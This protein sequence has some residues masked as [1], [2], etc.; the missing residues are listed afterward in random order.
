MINHLI[1]L[2]I[3]GT[4]RWIC[5]SF[6]LLFT[7]KKYLNLEKISFVPNFENMTT[8]WGRGD[9]EY[10]CVCV[11]EECVCEEYKEYNWG[12]KIT[13]IKIKIFYFEKNQFG[14]KHNQLHGKGS[15]RQKSERRKSKKV[16][17]KSKNLKRIRRL[18]IT[19]SKR[20]SKVDFWRSDLFWRHR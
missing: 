13:K 9:G 16:C 17:R 15:E 6:W 19:L 3:N 1:W 7:S 8:V 20:T 18:K 4:H 12:T 5:F 14:R 10:L 2:L 11:C